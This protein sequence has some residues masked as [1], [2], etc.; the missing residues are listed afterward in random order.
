MI[1]EADEVCLNDEEKE[2]LDGNA[3]EGRTKH[4]IGGVGPYAVA[5]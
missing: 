5:D 2:L 3:E 1:E 4:C